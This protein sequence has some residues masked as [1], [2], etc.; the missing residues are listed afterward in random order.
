MLE[1]M[2]SRRLMLP[3]LVAL[4]VVGCVKP[5]QP[6]DKPVFISGVYQPG[7]TSITEPRPVQSKYM[8][9]TTGGVQVVNGEATYLLRIALSPDAPNSFYARATFEN[10]SDFAEDFVQD[11]EF[12]TRPKV[13]TPAHGPV[14]GLEIFGE[15]RITVEL[16][17]RKGDPLPFDTISQVIRSY[18]DSQGEV[19]LVTDELEERK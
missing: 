1:S 6:A 12:T 10:P 19:A 9:V 2:S 16:Y 14:Y 5:P 13:L 7:R 11:G 3:L 8:S 17:E 15:Y 4:L 18:V